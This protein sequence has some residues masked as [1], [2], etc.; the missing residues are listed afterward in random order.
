MSDRYTRVAILL[1][2]L[3]ALF[4]VTLLALGLTME[5][6]PID[7]RRQAYQ[8]HKSLGLTVLVLTFVR[9][10]WRLTHKAPAL[11]DGMKPWEK[12]AAHAVHFGLYFIMLALP[13]S[14]WAMVSSSS[15]GYATE[16]FGLF[17]WPHISFLT[18]LENK[19]EVSHSFGEAHEVLANITIALLVLHVG[20]ALKHHIINRDG[21]LVRMLPFLKPLSPKE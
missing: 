16:F 7:I 14:G 13:L 1:H 2:W 9:I 6:L 20:A 18:T 11:P 5:D 4:I 3:I 19:K 10:F 12:F 8:F 21:V 17:D 15:R